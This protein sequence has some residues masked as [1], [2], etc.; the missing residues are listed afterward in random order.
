MK[1]LY[2]VFQSIFGCVTPTSAPRVPS[3]VC[4]CAA[5]FRKPFTPRKHSLLGIWH[6]VLHPTAT[7]RFETNVLPRV[8]ALIGEL[9]KVQGRVPTGSRVSSYGLSLHMDFPCSRLLA[10]LPAEIFA[11]LLI[12]SLGFQL[13]ILAFPR[14]C[15]LQCCFLQ[16]CFFQC[17]LL[18][19]CLLQVLLGVLVS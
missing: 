10:G 13:S 12:F 4:V 5:V 14:C 6:A 18:Q 8:G 9:E 17:C 16:C 19:C 1:S 3:A 11:D 2:N 7:L 15:F